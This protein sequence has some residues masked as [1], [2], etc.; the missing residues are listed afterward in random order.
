MAQ[1]AVENFALLVKQ[2]IFERGHLLLIKHLLYNLGEIATEDRKGLLIFIEETAEH[3]HQWVLLLLGRSCGLGLIARHI[4]ILRDCAC[5]FG[6]RLIGICW[7]LTLL[8]VLLDILFG[9]SRL[10]R[11]DFVVVS[12][13]FLVSVEDV[14]LQAHRGNLF[15]RFIRAALVVET[16]V[17]VESV[18]QLLRIRVLCIVLPRAKARVSNRSWF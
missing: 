12:A 8:A 13:V 7:R 4:L 17:L 6:V 2:K 9:C 16:K 18:N 15:L 3:V 5:K 11:V 1:K 10:S 14:L